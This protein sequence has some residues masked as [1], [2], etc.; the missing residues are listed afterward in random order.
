VH[1]IYVLEGPD[2]GG[3]TTLAQQFV[4][5][6]GAHYIH[7]TYRFKQQMF[8]YHWGCL[9]HA[10]VLARTQPVVIDR[11]WPSINIYDD[12]FRSQRDFPLAGRFLDRAGLSN[13][14]VYVLCLP[15]D[16]GIHLSR[17]E[18]K[19]KQGKEMFDTVA[20][21]ADKY[22]AWYK[23]LG[24]RADVIRYDW[25][26]MGRDM[27]LFANEV[28]R[29]WLQINTRIPHFMSN[30][31]FAG[32]MFADHPN[33]LIV[34]ERSNPK[35]RHDHWP[36]FEYGNSSLWLAE[37]LEEAGIAEYD[38]AWANAF[39][40]NG[41]SQPALLKEVFK[42]SGA[43]KIIAMGQKAAQVVWSAG[44]MAYTERMHHPAYARRFQSGPGSIFRN[45]Y[46]RD[47]KRICS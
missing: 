45:E 1:P 46:V 36:F 41:W 2:G 14:L 33:A 25:V 10:L 8:T 29:R 32:N 11:W 6:H 3:K 22:E 16:R 27:D 12:E 38:L 17:F 43:E 30:R 15:S 42:A 28:K 47:L 39:D 7:M 21:I 18:E 20:G 23:S 31:Q 9:E 19:A 26:T 40:K 35:N 37:C 44:L 34:G 5:Q 24:W 13:G 4:R